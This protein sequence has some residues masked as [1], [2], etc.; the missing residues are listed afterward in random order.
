M[1][2]SCREEEGEQDNETY[3]KLSVILVTRRG[4]LVAI[5]PSIHGTSD[6]PAQAWPESPILGPA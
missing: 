5:A 2:G 3:A 6:L 4:I 1:E